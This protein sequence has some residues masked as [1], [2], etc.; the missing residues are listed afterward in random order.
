MARR[1][2]ATRRGFAIVTADQTTPFSDT[3]SG[4]ATTR[5]AGAE[6]L[7]RVATLISIP[8]TAS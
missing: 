5:L 3:W 2:S 8:G 6:S 4:R 1:A 7:A